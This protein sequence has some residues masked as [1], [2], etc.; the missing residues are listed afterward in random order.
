MQKKVR[1]SRFKCKIESGSIEGYSTVPS[2]LPSTKPASSSEHCLHPAFAN[3]YLG[4]VKQK[5]VGHQMQQCH[6]ARHQVM[7]STA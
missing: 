4:K 7:S 1:E 3:L 6:S 2:L 5:L